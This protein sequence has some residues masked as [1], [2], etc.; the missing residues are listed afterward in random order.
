[1]LPLVTVVMPVRNEAGFI[2]RSL[3]RV[4]AQ[5][6]PAECMEVLVVDGMSTD[7]TREVVRRM[8]GRTADAPSVRIL[9]NP[10]R[11][12]PAALNVGIGRSAGQ[13]I[14]RVDGHCEIQPD[15]VRRCV[16]LLR[17]SGADNVGGLQ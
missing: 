11:V 5:D 8:A 10:S 7:E 16:E 17:T 2:E 4:L 1:G 15:H 12:V 6:Y 3:G 9:D 14:V 13:V